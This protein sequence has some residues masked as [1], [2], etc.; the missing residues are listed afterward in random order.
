MKRQV[1]WSPKA[2]SDL[3]EHVA[4]QKRVSVD[5]ASSISSKIIASGESLSTF[6]ERFEEFRM[7]R[8]FPFAVRKC[9]V[10]GRYIFLYAVKED[11][12]VIYRV[13]DARRKFGGL[14]R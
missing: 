12:V 6:P 5:A 4:L 8:N 11:S 13:L 9:V 3:G 14:L 7:P 10:D 2:A 1:R